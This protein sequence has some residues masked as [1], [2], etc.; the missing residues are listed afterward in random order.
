MTGST[1]LTLCNLSGLSAE[2]GLFGDECLNSAV[3]FG[4]LLFD[5]AYHLFDEP[6]GQV[7]AFFK[8]VFLAGN[9]FAE[10]ATAVH[11]LGQ[12]Q[13]AFFFGSLRR[14]ALFAGEAP[15]E[16]GVDGVGL[17]LEAF[18]LGE[19]FDAARVDQ[20]AGDVAF[21]QPL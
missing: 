4:D 3:D 5:G 21:P 2:G 1:P 9:L 15:D 16:P 20:A 11:E 19:A 13:V 18:A 17:G 6:C 8:T 12:G 14:K 7:C 10:V